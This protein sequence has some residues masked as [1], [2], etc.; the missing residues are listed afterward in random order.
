MLVVAAGFDV[1][2]LIPIAA[3]DV[4][5]P[6]PPKSAQLHLLHA[7]HVSKVGAFSCLQTGLVTATF[8]G[9]GPLY[10]AALGLD[11]H[12]ILVLMA[13][14]QLGGVVLQWPLGYASDRCDRRVM[15][16][17]MNIAVILLSLVLIVFGARLTLPVLAALLGG[18]AGIVESFYPIGVAHANDRAEP[19]DYVSLSSNLL[20]IWGVGSAIGPIVATAALDRLG[21]PGFF[22]YVVVLSAA[23]GIYTAWRIRRSATAADEMREEFVMYPTTSPEILELVP[24]RKL[25]R[26][27][28]PPEAS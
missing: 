1:L 26:P 8:S 3:L 18:F 28:A 22:W 14:M 10:G 20:L 5:A 12:A 25:K 11:Q 27:T 21:A 7:F 4:P 15:V 23:L 9:I 2:A 24:F 19:S 6:K 16:V 17:G 13:S